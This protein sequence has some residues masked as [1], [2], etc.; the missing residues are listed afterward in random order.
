MGSRIPWKRFRRLPLARAR[1]D[2]FVINRNVFGHDSKIEV[3]REFDKRVWNA[4][5][6]LND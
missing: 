5:W 6:L 2:L 4:E 1:L 3:A